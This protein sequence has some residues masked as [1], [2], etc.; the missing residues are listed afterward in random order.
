MND[1]QIPIPKDLPDQ[2]YPLHAYTSWGL[3]YGGPV[4]FFLPI[5]VLNRKLRA[6]SVS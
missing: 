6:E 4:A 3:N 1:G 2:N 5:Q